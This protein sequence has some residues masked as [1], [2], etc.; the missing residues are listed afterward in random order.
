MLFPSSPATTL[1]PFMG[2]AQ[3]RKTWDPWDP[4]LV[5][6]LSFPSCASCPCPALPKPDIFPR[7]QRDSRQSPWWPSGQGGTQA[8]RGPSQ[9][10]FPPSLLALPAGLQPSRNCLPAGPLEGAGFSSCDNSES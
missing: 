9:A 10:S 3:L 5:S 6:C 8:L 4:E 7:V 1:C 2:L